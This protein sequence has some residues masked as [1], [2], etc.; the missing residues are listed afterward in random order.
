VTV[1]ALSLDMVLVLR[2]RTNLQGEVS[3]D[4]MTSGQESSEA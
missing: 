1:V 4:H 3:A 2:L